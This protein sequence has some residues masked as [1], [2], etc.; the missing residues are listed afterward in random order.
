MRVPV[1]LPLEQLQPYL[2]DSSVFQSAIRNP[3]SAIE[4]PQSAIRN[5]QSAMEIPQSAIPINWPTVF[6]NDRPVEIEVG[7]G[8]GLFLL[9]A[10]QER[11]DVNFLGIE[12]ERKYQL[13]TANRIA[14]RKLGNVRLVCTD[15]REFLRDC[16]PAGSVQGLHVYFP[17]PWWK[18]RHHKR[19]LFAVDFAETCALVLKEGGK[20]EVMSD[21]EEYFGII[22]ELLARQQRLR[23]VLGEDGERR[24]RTNFERKYRLAGKP[25]FGASYQAR[26]LGTLP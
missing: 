16:V 23:P 2:L 21:V 18:K 8:K 25:I 22:Q 6:G 3:Q 4:V 9:T 15:A 17:D 24:Y 14:K 13:F 20:L 1:R 26:A 11:P 7:F 12:I 19:R 5:P 10:S